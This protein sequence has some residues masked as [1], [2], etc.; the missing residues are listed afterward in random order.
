MI[1]RSTLAM[2]IAIAAP[3]AIATAEETVAAPALSSASALKASPAS[4][5][6]DVQ[7][8]YDYGPYA[9]RPVYKYR[10]YTYWYPTYPHW[11][12]YT[13]STGKLV[14]APSLVFV[15]LTRSSE[16]RGQSAARIMRTRIR[17]RLAT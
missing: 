6:T 11:D 12:P 5:V 17:A 14:R 10:G 8:I 15:S 1:K 3:L 16:C 4:A 9:Y 7:Y 2:A 13:W